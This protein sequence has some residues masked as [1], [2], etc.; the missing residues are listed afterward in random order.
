MEKRARDKEKRDEIKARLKA[1]NFV[2][3]RPI[4]RMDVDIVKET[5]KGSG[6]HKKYT[7]RKIKN[8]ID[9]YFEWCET[10]DEVPS[11]KG[12][13]IH[14]K[15]Y[16]DQFYKYLAYPEFTDIME[17]AR[18]II[19]NWIETDIYNTKGMAAGKIAY[20]KNAQGIGWT[21]KLESTSTVTQTVISV[22]AAR[23]KIE[24]LAPRLLE[25][26][27]ND[28]VLHQLTDNKVVEAEIVPNKRRIG[29]K[30][31]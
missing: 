6:R 21:D 13:M 30:S 19:S 4:P 29:T 15:M 8:L 9:S 31:A 25:L 10:E 5:K 28:L 2:V 20:A 18:M 17:H 7:P 27:K 1:E 12:M 16:K 14:L 3:T 24:M 22:D 11:I 26:L 23:A